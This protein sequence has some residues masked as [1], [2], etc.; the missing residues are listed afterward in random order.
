M[1]AKLLGALGAPASQSRSQLSGPLSRAPWAPTQ[2]PLK[3]SPG[4]SLRGLPA[5]F[6]HTQAEPHPWVCRDTAKC[7][8]IG[9][10]H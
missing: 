10:G 3:K 9:S 1:W 7:F 8:V 6:G 4:P 5:L 2:L